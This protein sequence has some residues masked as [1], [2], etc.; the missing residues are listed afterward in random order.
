MKLSPKKRKEFDKVARMW[1]KWVR[2]P[3]ESHFF[4][5]CPTHL[6]ALRR[7]VDGVTDLSGKRK[8]VC[9]Y[10][11]CEN[12]ADKELFP[13]LVEILEGRDGK[14]GSARQQV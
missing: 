11:G 12:K 5:L 6:N 1:L 14:L 4:F 10:P 2:N 8:P 7:P 9:D 3:K 13:N